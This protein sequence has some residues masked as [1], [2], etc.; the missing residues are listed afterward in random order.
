MPA[1]SRV[2]RRQKD[3]KSWLQSRAM[4]LLK[5]CERCRSLKE[6]GTLSALMSEKTRE[7]YDEWKRADAAAR[8]VESRLQAVWAAWDMGADP[9]TAAVLAEVS[10]LR[11]VANYRLAT[12][13]ASLS[14]PNFGRRADKL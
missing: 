11:S 12:V 2:I 14:E 1:G 4:A 8:E 7:A 3:G 5:R 6:V 9:P 10:R 13:V